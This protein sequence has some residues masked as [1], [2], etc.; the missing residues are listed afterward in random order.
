MTDNIIDLS[1]ARAARG[2]GALKLVRVDLVAGKTPDGMV[3]LLL[4]PDG[5]HAEAV[6]AKLGVHGFVPSNPAMLAADIAALAADPEPE[7]PEAGA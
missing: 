1:A 2:P 4:N 7:D 3:V 6:A 5:P